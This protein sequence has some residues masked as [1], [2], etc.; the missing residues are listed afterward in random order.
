M[1]GSGACCFAEFGSDAAARAAAAELPA[2]LH[3]FIAR[4]LDLHPL[5]ALT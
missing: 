3:H 4:G 2:P 1:S 5:S